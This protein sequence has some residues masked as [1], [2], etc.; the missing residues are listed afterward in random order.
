ME[1]D[2]MTRPLIDPE[3]IAEAK[4]DL[5][6]MATAHEAMHLEA[7]LRSMARPNIQA[8]GA[9]LYCGEP[10]AEGLRWCPA[11]LGEAVEDTCMAAWEH[12]QERKKHAC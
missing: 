11:D 7:S 6:D 1:P 3:R 5:Y 8:T 2:E 12:E 10:L 9:C 4:S